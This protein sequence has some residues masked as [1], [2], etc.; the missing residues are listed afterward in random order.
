VHLSS[1]FSPFGLTL[2]EELIP[3]IVENN[4]NQGARKTGWKNFFCAQGRCGYQAALRPDCM[5]LLILNHFQKAH[6]GILAS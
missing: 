5:A 4:K 3:Q 6:H 2:N 1:V